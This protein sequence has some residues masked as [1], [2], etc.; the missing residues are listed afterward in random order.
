[1]TDK[2]YTVPIL[3]L[4]TT[5]GPLS[6][7][8]LGTSHR[9]KTFYI[10][11]PSESYNDSIAWLLL[12]G[13]FDRWENWSS[14]KLLVHRFKVIELVSSR[15]STETQVCIT[16]ESIFIVTSQQCFLAGS[17]LIMVAVRKKWDHLCKELN[18]VPGTEYTGTTSRNYVTD[19]NEIWAS[20]L[21]ATQ[22]WLF[23]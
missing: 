22:T 16:P 14:E 4:L 2:I 20:K 5:C 6:E 19:F 21:S 10:K 7:H 8:L 3:T 1:M 12:S 15:D 23:G 18:I 17:Y 13:P 9:A 11:H